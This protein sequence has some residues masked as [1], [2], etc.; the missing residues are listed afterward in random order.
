MK[1]LKIFILALGIASFELCVYP[2]Y[3]ITHS[4]TQYNGHQKYCKCDECQKYKSLHVSS[5]IG[6]LTGITTGTSNLIFNSLQARVKSPQL[7]H[8]IQTG[9]SVGIGLLVARYAYLKL[10]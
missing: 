5:S 2:K 6:L 8:R 9:A 3:G 4:G 1:I 7:A 10:Q